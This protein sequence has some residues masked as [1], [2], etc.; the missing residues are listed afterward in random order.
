MKFS[1]IGFLTL[2]MISFGFS[3]CKDKA[4]PTAQSAAV[5]ETEAAEKIAKKE[6][7]E[8]IDAKARPTGPTSEEIRAGDLHWRI[9]ELSDDK[10]EGRAPATKGGQAAAKWMADE[11]KRIGLAPAGNARSYFQKVPLVEVTM[12]GERSNFDVT[13]NSETV[14]MKSG[15]D[16]VYWTK[17]QVEQTGFENAEFV[18]VG[19]GVVAPEYGWDDYAGLDVK[20]KIVVM[21]VN[22]PGYAKPDG[23][24]FKGKAMTYYGRW[25]Y[26]YE[27]AAR[28]GAAG[29]LVVHETAPASYPWS[30][31]SGSW[32][33][34]QIDQ[35]RA[36]N[37]MDRIP[38]EGWIAHAKAK[39]LFGLAGLDYESEKIRAAQPGFSATAMPG[40]MA[41]AQIHNSLAYK[42]SNN[43]VGKL[44]GTSHPDEYVLYMAHWDHLGIKPV[45]EGEDGIFNG[46]VDN[47]T[48]TAGV[49]EIAE[50]FAAAPPKRSAVFLLVTAEESGL[51]GSAYFADNPVVP[52]ANIVGGVNMDGVLPV[53]KSRDFSVVG[54]GASELEDLLAKEASKIGK[55][56]TPDA[57]PEAGYFYRSDHISL[58]KKGVPMLYA[59]GGFDLVDGGVEAGMAAADDY[60]ANHYHQP[61][62]EYSSDWDL[63]GIEEDF[64]VLY[65]LGYNL[66]NQPGLWPNWY[67]GNEFKPLRDE[68]RTVVV[69]V[70]EP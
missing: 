28:Q 25:T 4:E 21:L 11:M 67:E 22:D 18:F 48:G 69:P 42:A 55:S 16:I 51:L 17:R 34:S 49:L 8:K 62:D 66:A 7:S 24:L 36:E 27:E 38:V 45:A 68:Q 9:K 47:A 65:S 52:L 57:Q 19:Y 10:Y 14:E 64:T 15:D 54:F 63:S 5:T 61:S 33:G 31:V 2:M 60:R 58:A 1:T 20:G 56:L 43:I 44:V 53:G 3:A 35:V 6:S 29:A 32:S 30:V 40:L 13:H 50:K 46:A 12:D 26:K 59:D 23:E 41:S 37:G 70:T 39:Q